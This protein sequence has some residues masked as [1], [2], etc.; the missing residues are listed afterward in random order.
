MKLTSIQKRFLLFLG[1]CIPVR[2]LFV[3]VAWTVSIKYLRLL[4]YIALLP[5]IG[6]LYLFVSGKRQVG[7]ETQGE[8][9][10]WSKFR[11]IHGIMYLLFAIYAI[12]GVR[13]A[14]LF[15]LIDVLIGL[16]LFLWFH[17]TNGNIK[18]LIM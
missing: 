6:F 12:K 16:G 4:G 5:A 18:K 10:W 8:P 3:F 14:Y 2:L 15:L 17:Y 13:S 1:A 11:S 9:I 7:L